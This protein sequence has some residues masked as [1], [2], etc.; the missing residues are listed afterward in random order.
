MW[1]TL[2]VEFSH[3]KIKPIMPTCT[4]LRLKWTIWHKTKPIP[5]D[6]VIRL[7]NLVLYRVLYNI[8]HFCVHGAK[9]HLSAGWPS[10]PSA[11]LNW[12][13]SLWMNTRAPWSFQA[14]SLTIC[15]NPT[16]LP[17]PVFVFSNKHTQTQQGPKHVTCEQRLNLSS[18][19]P[20]DQIK[21]LTLEPFKIF[22]GSTPVT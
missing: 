11:S 6:L 3:N 8:L 7:K 5:G 20:T 13:T 12:T 22:I 14:V 9:F 4:R 10:M 15:W 17:L 21:E 18:D 19:Y 2:F 16:D 1:A